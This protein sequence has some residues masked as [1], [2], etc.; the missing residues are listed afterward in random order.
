MGVLRAAVTTGLTAAWAVSRRRAVKTFDAASRHPRRAQEAWLARAWP[1]LSESSYGRALGLPTASSLEAF[2]RRAPVVGWD[3]V[4]PLVARLAAGERGVLTTEPVLVF[5]RTSGSTATPKRV[6]YTQGLLDDFSAAT[7]PWLDDLF[8]HFPGLFHARQYWSLSPAARAP[9]TTPSGVRVGFEDD[10]EYFGPVTRLAMKQLMAVP[11]AVGQLRGVEAWTLATL[12]PLVEAAD[13][14]FISVWNPSFLTLLLEALEARW[15]EVLP[16]LSPARR[17]AVE[18]LPARTA[19]ALWPSLQLVSCWTDGWAKAALPGLRRLAPRVPI[20]GKGLL[21]TE[22][23]VSFPRWGLPAPVAAVTSHLLEFE[24]LDGGGPLWVDELRAGAR[25]TP[26]LTTRGGLL[27][28]RLPDVV[29]CVGHWR[30]LPMLRFEGRSDKTSDLRGEKLSAVAVEP[31]L[32]RALRGLPLAFALLAPRL[33]PTAG[34]TLFLE[35]PLD[36]AQLRALADAVETALLEEHHYR[37]C[38]D[39][40]QL[41]GVDVVRVEGG[42]QRWLEALT[43]RGLK[44]G[45]IKPSAFDPSPDWARWLSPPGTRG[46]SP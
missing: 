18:A 12:V 17:R 33:E 43:A 11:G 1:A 19:E 34:Y 26:V 39:L 44:L 9:E 37:Y 13:L 42:R 7:G 36:D 20:Q 24:P 29:T 40:G 10:T 2:R 25:Y 32:E 14:G 6:P 45:D 27:R 21:A 35:G 28:Y 23:V 46:P 22:G 4:A 16:R 41:S 38:R 15:G 31:K 3:D 30:A 8:R 5:E